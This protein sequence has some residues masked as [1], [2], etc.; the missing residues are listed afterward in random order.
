M[1]RTKPVGR[2]ASDVKEFEFVVDY[3]QGVDPLMDVFHEHPSLSVRSSACYASTETMW[4]IDHATGPRDALDRF[5][6]RFLDENRCNECVTT[7]DCDTAREY[8]VLDRQPNGRTVYTYREEVHRCHSIPHFVVDHV[9]TGVVFQSRRTDG[10]YRWKVLYQHDEPIGPLFDAI[11]ADLLDGISLEL[12]HLRQSGNWDPE[13]RTAFELS[14]D[15]WE[16]LET[17]VEAGYYERPRGA[18]VADLAEQLDL[19]RSTA[20]YR[21][22]AAEDVVVREFVGNAL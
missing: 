7:P 17:A 10:E 15:Q 3:D 8:H 18:T 5:G 22:R 2:V 16:V 4:R 20:Q 12:A 14:H 19:P 9:G 1:P 6:E 11:E 13:T 21:L